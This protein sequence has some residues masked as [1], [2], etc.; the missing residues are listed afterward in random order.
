M[1]CI[2]LRRLYQLCQQE[3]LRLGG[4]D[5]IHIVCEQCGEQE[6]CPAMLMDEYEAR[7]PQADV[8]P[9]LQSS[10]DDA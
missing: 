6:V 3:G 1:T 4:T 7:H 8:E 5:L 9:P 2:H 10:A